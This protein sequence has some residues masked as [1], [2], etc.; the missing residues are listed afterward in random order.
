MATDV[1]NTPDIVAQETTKAQEAARSEQEGHFAKLRKKTEALEYALQEKDQMLRQQ[2]Q[3]LEQLNSRFQPQERDEF[4]SLSDEEL[5][6]KAKMKRVLEKERQKILGEAEKIARQTYQKIDSENYQRK[7][8]SQYPD[9]DQV[10][11]ETGAEKLR[12]KDPEFF[13]A[14]SKIGDEYERRELAYKK[15]KRLIQEDSKPAPAPVK[16]QDVANENRMLGNAY[17]NPAGQSLMSSTSTEFDVKS[18]A[19]RK[20]AYERLKAAQK[21]AF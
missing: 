1:Q 17:Y 12:E 19:A 21:R 14:L 20:A 10:V 11:N 8:Y 3:M 7:I 15:I 2:Q 6:D 5:I 4:D 18:P 13:T 9:Y 16:A